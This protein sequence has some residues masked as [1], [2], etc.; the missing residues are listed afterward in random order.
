MTDLGLGLL[1]HGYQA[2][3]H[4]RAERDGG[5]A[6]QTR[7]LGRRAVVLGGETGARFFYN[8]NLVERRGA[9]PPPLAWLL[10]GRGAVHGLDEDA[11]RERKQLFLDQ[12]APG[13]V[14]QVA[15][16]V[17]GQL[18]AA[19]ISWA[20]REVVVYDELVEVFGS[21]VLTW[22]GVD[23]SDE[24]QRRLSHRYAAI[25]DGFGF[26]GSAYLRAWAARRAT[27]A[28]ARELI[29]EARD[30]RIKAAEG[31]VLSAL[32][33]SGLDNRM[34]G[35]ELGNIVRPTVAVSWLGT[36]A[37]LALAEADQTW[38]AQLANPEAD[39]LR[40][41]FAQEVR[42]TTP[43]VP[44]LAGRARCDTT[45]KGISIHAGNRVILD[46][47]GIN[48]DPTHFEDPLVFRPDRFIDLEPNAY[49]LVP[50]GGGPPTG[51]RCPGE[52][53]TLQLLAHTIAIFA[54]T[55]FTI[56]SPR[57]VDPSRIPT[58]PPQGLRIRVEN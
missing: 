49:E 20:G 19:I 4:D 15:E 28:W 43:F 46:V 42:R 1:R 48:L 29:A 44:A 57:D 22:V 55:D 41:A 39:T 27:D 40:W 8:E 13:Q 21:A 5:A 10:F 3:D 45:H 56:V 16:S 54:E 12:L 11:H 36:H 24:E 35:V 26:A 2:I 31:T 53:L 9:V 17:G 33:S 34:A 30:G 51:H 18:K 7:L 6:Y 50:Q 23:L 32:A 14:A 47:R 37:V 58:L 52:S 25:V 38:H